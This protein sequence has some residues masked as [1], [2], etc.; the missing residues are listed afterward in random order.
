MAVLNC[1]NN[2][3]N[4]LSCFRAI[5]PV[6]WPTSCETDLMNILWHS[7]SPSLFA[8]C[9]A[10]PA[11]ITNNIR[12]IKDLQLRSCQ[13][14]LFICSLIDRLFHF[15]FNKTFLNCTH[16]FGVISVWFSLLH[17]PL[18][19]STDL[20]LYI[21][22]LILSSWLSMPVCWHLHQ[23]VQLTLVLAPCVHK[24]NDRTKWTF[25][26]HYLIALRRSP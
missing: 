15:M 9:C 3:L 22:I 20:F 1:L 23:T 24:G 5:I 18:F 13:G 16:L 11:P 4:G 25:C 8:I 17:L 10:A 6:M 21:L 2:C 19:T 7:A 12:W 14:Y 26:Y